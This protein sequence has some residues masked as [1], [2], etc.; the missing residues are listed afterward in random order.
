MFMAFCCVSAEVMLLCM[1]GMCNV[2]P[3]KVLGDAPAWA[4]SLSSL[5]SGSCNFGKP[6]VAVVGILFLCMPGAMVKQCV[7]MYQLATAA[8][9]IAELD[10]KEE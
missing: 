1:F 2:L 7:N 6:D 5:I 10:G 3:L 4:A 9:K 8:T